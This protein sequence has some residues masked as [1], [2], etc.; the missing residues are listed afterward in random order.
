MPEPKLRGRITERQPLPQEPSLRPLEEKCA[1]HTK[2]K[3]LQEFTPS[4]AMQVTLGFDPAAHKSISPS[5][6]YF[7]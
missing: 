4:R 2:R 1:N 3:Q 5:L 7:L 6:P